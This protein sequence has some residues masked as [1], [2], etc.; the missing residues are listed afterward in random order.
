MRYSV[1]YDD[2]VAQWAVIDTRAAG[3]EI[4]THGD[5][6]AAEAAARREEQTWPTQRD[7]TPSEI[8]SPP[9]HQSGVGRRG[10]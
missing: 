1:I 4:A 2:L 7:V 5:R 3:L 8:P 9:S 6:Q 10:R